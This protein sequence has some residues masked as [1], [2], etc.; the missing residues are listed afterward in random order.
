[1]SLQ[2]QCLC[3]FP[4][5]TVEMIRAR[6]RALTP[7]LNFSICS[8]VQSTV[9]MIRARSRALT[10]GCENRCVDEVLLVEMIRARSRALTH[11]ISSI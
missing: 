2:S 4:E 10:H 3:G 8:C 1:M 5:G 7:D 11:D 6:S 9:E